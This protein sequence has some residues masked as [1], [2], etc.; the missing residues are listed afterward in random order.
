M[1]YEN[2]RR[3]SNIEDVRGMGG[4]GGGGLGG[5]L[6]FLLLRSFGLRGLVILG[7]VLLGINFLAP[8][9]I[10]NLVFNQLLGGVFGSSASQQQATV[11][12][13]A[14]GDPV[15]DKIA[16]YL[17]STEDVWTGIFQ[18]GQ[19]PDY[20]HPTTTYTK[21]VLVLFSGSVDTGCGGASSDSG[22]FYCPQDQKLYIDP[23][24]YDVLAQRLNSPGDFAQAYVVAHEIGH[25]VQQLIGATDAGPQGETQNQHSVRVELQADCFAGVWGHTAQANLHV[26]DQ[27]V[28]QALNA[29]HNI[30][31][32]TLQNGGGDP[33]QYTH[34]TSAQ[35]MRWFKRG[36]DTGDARQCDTMRAAQL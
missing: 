28:A 10:K 36:F 7:V 23:T 9:G 6:P 32:D 8:V 12:S 22:P 35:R 1:E 27:D 31:D 11:G 19:L 30:G 33:R 26:T 34:G 18:S 4:G 21:P 24:F 5:A 25:H 2:Q 29:A 14:S 16:A 20:G 3:S 13:C 17:G 15:C